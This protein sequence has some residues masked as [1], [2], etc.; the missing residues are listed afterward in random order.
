MDNG[1]H[2]Y[3]NHDFF[4]LLAN[5]RYN[6]M[7]PD[8]S[9]TSKGFEQDEVPL[10]PTDQTSR[11]GKL[12]QVRGPVAHEEQESHFYDLPTFRQHVCDLPCGPQ[13]IASF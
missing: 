13:K 5:P 10:L 6:A 4:T 7:K 12:T 8:L 9:E 1:A 2:P 3:A 11:G